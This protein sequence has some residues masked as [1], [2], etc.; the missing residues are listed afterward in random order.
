MAEFIGM[1]PDEVELLS[2]QLE[3]KAG[4][5][6]TILSTLTSALAGTTWTGTDYTRFEEAWQGTITPN[7]TN[8]ANQLHEASKSAYGDAQAQRNASS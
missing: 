1:N 5:I 7:L 2:Q 6:E 3:T 8:A 4:D